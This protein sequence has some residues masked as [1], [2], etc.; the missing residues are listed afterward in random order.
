MYALYIAVLYILYLIYLLRC[1]IMYEGV[2]V[3]WVEVR[4]G[5]PNTS[6][7]TVSIFEVATIVQHYLKAH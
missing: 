5:Q 2:V 4:I 7:C 1:I 3:W 6:W